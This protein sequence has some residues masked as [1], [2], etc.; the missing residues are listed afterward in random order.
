VVAVLG[1]ALSFGQSA[2]ERALGQ[3]LA[4][5]IERR[6]T[7][8][9]DADIVES[10]ER[11]ARKLSVQ[12]FQNAVVETHV[13]LS[14]D[15]NGHALPGGVLFINT[16]LIHEAES[17]AELAG[18]IAHLIARVIPSSPENKA[19]VVFIGGRSG[20]SYRPETNTPVAFASA[21]Q[22]AVSTADARAIQC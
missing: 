13:V 21:Q 4:T 19:P 15:P 22:A 7:V 2:K 6:E 5:E 16:G 3:A 11:M 1:M 14:S 17:E 8:V 18:A 10:V 20:Y 12:C 9:G